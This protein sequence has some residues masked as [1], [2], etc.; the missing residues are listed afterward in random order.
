MSDEGW[1]IDFW[2]LLW[3]VPRGH[4]R[5][6]DDQ[7]WLKLGR[8]RD[9]G[10]GCWA[11]LWD[12]VWLRLGTVWLLWTIAYQW[13]LDWL[14]NAKDWDKDLDCWLSSEVNISSHGLLDYY[15]SEWVCDRINRWHR[16]LYHC[17][18]Y[19][20]YPNTTQLWLIC[21]WR[22]SLWLRS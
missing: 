21:R 8:Q 17:R 22:R 15:E 9:M 19:R 2:W 18:V 7:S 1:I 10:L 3:S 14:S 13:S 5:W 20:Q 4:V 12:R 11:R 16:V 6:D